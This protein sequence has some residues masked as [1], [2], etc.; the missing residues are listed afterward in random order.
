MLL[1]SIFSKL[2]E[3]F[4]MICLKLVIIPND[5]QYGFTSV[6]GFQRALLMSSCVVDHYKSRGSSVY[7][8]GSD[9]YEKL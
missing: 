1:I 4:V 5:L 7:L 8:A 2:F 6:N 3:I 9:V